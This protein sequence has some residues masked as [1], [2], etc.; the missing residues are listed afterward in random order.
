MTYVLHLTDEYIV[1]Y[2]DK[3]TLCRLS[4]S[5]EEAR[6]SLEAHLKDQPAFCLIIDQ[7]FQHTFDEKLPPLWPWDKARLLFHKKASLAHRG[8]YGGVQL[9]KSH[10]ETYLRSVHISLSHPL[11]VWLAWAQLYRGRVHVGPLEGDLFLK[12]HTKSSK[13]YHLLVYPLSSD[14]KRHLVFKGKHLLLCRIVPSEE[15]P[16]SALHFL[17]RTYPDLYQYLEI[18]SLTEPFLFLQFITTQSRPALSLSPLLPQ[19]WLTFLPWLALLFSFSWMGIAVYQGVEFQEKIKDLEDQ[20]LSLQRTMKCL[21]G[22][23]KQSLSRAAIEGYQ[24]LLPRFQDPLS[25]I[26]V[27]AALLEDHSLY[28]EKLEMHYGAG[29]LL[30]LDFVIDAPTRS[31]LATYFA[32]FLESCHEAFPAARVDVIQAPFNSGLHEIFTTPEVTRPLASIRIVIP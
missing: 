3:E 30:T 28:L 6:P 26:E 10:P 1:L 4:P 29:R 7:D 20:R 27:L 11:M 18:T 31:E 16:H 8:G 9:I 19:K 25:D 17:S 21:S 5:F 32:D 23:K 14:K 2:Q 24:K 13:S 15:E 12:H 22:G